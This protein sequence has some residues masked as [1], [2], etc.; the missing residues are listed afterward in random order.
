MDMNARASYWET[1]ILTASPQKLRLM[2][3]EG[4]I[5]TARHVLEYWEENRQ[6]DAFNAMMRCQNIVFELL[7]TINKNGSE[8]NRR[9]ASVYVFLYR[10]LVEAQMTRDAKR[11][12]EVIR[13]LEEER[14]TWQLVCEQ[15][16]F[17]PS[18]EEMSKFRTQE[19]TASEM[20]AIHSGHGLGTSHF[21]HSDSPHT[22]L[23]NAGFLMDA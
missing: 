14:E 4:A 18:A 20:P 22:S 10:S 1:Q 19:I 11:V 6:D 17:A 8:L 15:N 9:I 21:S 13:V 2:L 16:P 5:R 3:I 12:S 7:T 23:D